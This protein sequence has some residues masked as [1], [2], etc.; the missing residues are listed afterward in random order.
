MT[1]NWCTSMAAPLTNGKPFCEAC[2]SRCYRECCRCRR[3]FQS[4]K[5]FTEDLTGRRC[6]SCQR[7]YL[8]EMSTV[9]KQTVVS[10]ESNGFSASEESTTELVGRKKK[11][12]P[13]VKRAAGQVARRPVKKRKPNQTT[14]LKP[15][16]PFSVIG[17]RMRI[18]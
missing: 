6:N 12:N 7:K 3:P 15:S 9:S 13:P 17:R 4:A 5:Y 16:R 2:R 10:D 18:A 8:K 1:C 11:R 14:P